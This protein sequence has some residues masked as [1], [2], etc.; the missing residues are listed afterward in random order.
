MEL[1]G[2][3]TPSVDGSIS[4]PVAAVGTDVECLEHIAAPTRKAKVV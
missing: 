1:D 2:G 4:V 3:R